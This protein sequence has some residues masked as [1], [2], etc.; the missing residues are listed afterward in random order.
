MLSHRETVWWS[1]YS[2]N[3]EIS[4]IWIEIWFKYLIAGCFWPS[5]FTTLNVYDIIYIVV[6]LNKCKRLYLM[7]Q[8]YCQ[9][10]GRC[11]LEANHSR[12]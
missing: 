9:A 11:L 10:Y 4:K 2:L 5:Q 7:G 3:F 12:G 8:I 6:P 1:G